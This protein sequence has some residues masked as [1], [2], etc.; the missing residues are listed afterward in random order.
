MLA[1][2]TSNI[3]YPCV[4]FKATFGGGRRRKDKIKYRRGTIASYMAVNKKLKY[5][6]R[7]KLSDDEHKR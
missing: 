3:L 1:Q 6:L 2:R 4:P 5:L 7:S